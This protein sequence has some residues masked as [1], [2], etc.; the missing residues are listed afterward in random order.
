VLLAAARTRTR[1]GALFAES[2]MAELLGEPTVLV[3][4]GVGPAHVARGLESAAAELGVDLFVFVDVGGMP[5]DGT[6]PGLASLLRDAVMLAAARLSAAAR[7]RRRDPARVRRRAYARELLGASP[8]RRRRRAARDRG[9]ER[10]GDGG[11]RACGG[12]DTDGGSAQAV[13]AARRGRH[14]DDPR[15]RRAASHPAR[16]TTVYMD[17]AL[18]VNGAAPLAS[19]VDDARDLEEAQSRLSALGVHTELDYEREASDR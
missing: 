9:D 12:I 17:P 13:S 1:G 6:E 11:S 14:D 2:R 7:G 3:D 8:R 16:A 19:A 15:R 4:P 5:A 10:G 18:A